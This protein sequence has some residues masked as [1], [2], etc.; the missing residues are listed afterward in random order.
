MHQ[1]SESYDSY[2]LMPYFGFVIKSYAKN[3]NIYEEP[4]IKNKK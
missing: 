3:L 2:W 1:T 4:K